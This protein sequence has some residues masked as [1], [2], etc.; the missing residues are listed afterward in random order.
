MQERVTR[1]F[2]RLAALA[3]L[4]MSLVIATAGGPEEVVAARKPSPSD[5]PVIAGFYGSP[6]AKACLWHRYK[7][8]Y[9]VGQYYTVESDPL[10]PLTPTD[11]V[12]QQVDVSFT[13]IHGTADPTNT[14]VGPFSARGQMLVRTM[15][16]TPTSV[17]TDTMTIKAKTADGSWKNDVKFDV[18]RCKAKIRGTADMTPVTSIANELGG[19]LWTMVA[20]LD[21]EGEA[22]V[23][24]NAVTGSGTV[25]FFMYEQFEGI[26][27]NAYTCS[28]SPPWQ[29]SG[30]LGVTGDAA[31]LDDGQLA[32]TL[33]IAPIP[34]GA[35][36]VQCTGQVGAGGFD[37]PA[38]D[39]PAQTVALAAVPMGGG[40]VDDELPYGQFVLPF[41]VSVVEREATS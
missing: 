5:T 25:R 39:L 28:M 27:Q 18:V 37:L 41:T 23:V 30:D 22:E 3:A 11:P 20:S 34:L 35:T 29:G 36:R 21:V 2:G 12:A 10:A 1:S 7:L 8:D 14:S 33:D 24:E 16:Y 38:G 13:T 4:S 40:T 17:G 9:Y 26:A 6:G 15:T 19:G 31:V 32:L